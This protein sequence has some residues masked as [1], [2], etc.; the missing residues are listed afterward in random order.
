MLID[1]LSNSTKIAL[2]LD[3]DTKSLT[4]GMLDRRARRVAAFLIKRGAAGRSVLLM[5][6]AGLDFLPSFLGCLY[7]GAIAVPV[8]KPVRQDSANRLSQIANDCGPTL[9]LTVRKW[10][11]TNEE[12]EWICVDDDFDAPPRTVAPVAGSVAYL[13]Y[14]S[15][16]TGLSRGVE[17]TH[18]ALVHNLHCLVATIGLDQHTVCVTW[19]PHFHDMGLVG[20]LL[21]PLF[22]GGTVVILSPFDFV[23]TPVRW[24]RALSKY[25]GTFTASP[26]FGYELCVQ[27][28]TP[29]DR[30]E[31]DLS[32]WR[33]A[34]NGAEM[35]RAETVERFIDAFAP[36]GFRE[37]TMAP[38][39]GLAEATL[40][41][42]MDRQGASFV[43]FDRRLLS[44]GQVQPASGGDAVVLVGCGAPVSETEVA[45]VDPATQ[46][47]HAPNM[48]GEIWVRGGSIAKG[49]HHRAEETEIQFGAQIKGED[50]RAYL[51][52]GDIGFIHDGKLL[53]TGRIKDIIVIRGLKIHPQDIESTAQTAH[54]ALAARTVV[55]SAEDEGVVILQEIKAPLEPEQA[56]EALAKIRGAINR[57]HGIDPQ[58][59]A[60]FP[61]RTIAL[62]SSGK[63]ARW[64]SRLAWQERRI[65]AIAH[66]RR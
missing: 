28:T 39:Y 56:H 32:N 2:R 33:V 13:Q 44:Q 24:L 42:S 16:S 6:P 4:Y 12:I 50:G 8:A 20:T 1:C 63:L 61:R 15:G 9:G 27:R 17:I 49:Y 10:L 64:E 38:C 3:D 37:K 22:A 59:I 66:W 36:A 47:R 7:A 21:A 30:A 46:L 41:V 11:T 18:S 62:T 57:V 34:A 40:I 54:P 35:V 53:V 31:L 55:Y 60:L 29:A 25:R 45:I 51:R 58:E 14:T 65:E 23:Q 5:F 48:I 26:N 52:T 19:L 43:G